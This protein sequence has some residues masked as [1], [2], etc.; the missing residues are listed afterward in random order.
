MCSHS[1]HVQIMQLQEHRAEP[2]A[3]GL[4]GTFLLLF[5]LAPWSG[6]FHC[7]WHTV[8]PQLHTWHFILTAILPK[9]GP[10][11]HCSTEFP[12]RVSHWPVFSCKQLS[13]AAMLP[14]CYRFTRFDEYTSE[15]KS[16]QHI[17]SILSTYKIIYMFMYL[18]ICYFYSI[19]MILL[20][21]P[22]LSW[23]ILHSLHRSPWHLVLTVHFCCSTL[24]KAPF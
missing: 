23:G 17:H 1:L 12:K 22:S 5:T 20:Q 16:M 2:R 18:A 3:E 7:Q 11:F 19:P 8:Q 10:L 4:T 9:K 15:S 6:V 21:V 13:K 14:G 24:P